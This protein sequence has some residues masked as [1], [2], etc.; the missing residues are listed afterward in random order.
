MD[1][2]YLWTEVKMKRIKKNI[3]N[4]EGIL[5]KCHV[6]VLAF[7]CGCRVGSL[8]KKMKGLWGSLK[9]ACG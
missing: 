9:I 7:L 5:G 3:Q 2:N 1:K 8:G 4:D 6:E